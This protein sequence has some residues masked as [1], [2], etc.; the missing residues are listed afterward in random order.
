MYRAVRTM[1]ATVL[2][3]R[4]FM[5][6]RTWRL[7]VWARDPVDKAQPSPNCKRKQTTRESIDGLPV[8]RWDGLLNALSTQIRNV[9]RVGEGKNQVSI[10]RETKPNAFQSRAFALLDADAPCWPKICVQ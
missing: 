1:V 2:W 9:C 8:R 7:C 4:C 6:K 10:I 3:L 5:P